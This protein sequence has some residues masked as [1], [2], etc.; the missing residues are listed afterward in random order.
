MKNIGSL[1]VTRVVAVAPDATLEEA[2]THMK[3]SNV[4]VLPVI[5]GGKVIGMV[6]DRDIVIRGVADGR[7]PDRTR[8]NEV[9]SKNVVSCNEEDEIR[10]AARLMEEHRVGRVV[11]L[12]REGNLKGI[13]SLGNLAQALGEE[14]LAGVLEQ[15]FQRPRVGSGLGLGLLLTSA[16]LGGIWLTNRPEIRERL[17]S[18][19]RERAEGWRAA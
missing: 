11:I 14:H 4:G 7:V 9:M 3:R 13:L 1:M 10:H 12:D 17:F 8:V 16:I 18:R 19:I 2:A 5:L 15:K 6:T